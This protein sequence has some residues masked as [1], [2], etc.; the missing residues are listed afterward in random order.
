V[1]HALAVAALLA[2]ALAAGCG[3][4]SSSELAN[5][6]E[7]LVLLNQSDSIVGTAGLPL[8]T[9]IQL[10]AQDAN[11]NPIAGATIVW[12]ITAGNGSVSAMQDTTGSGGLV[13][14]IWTLGTLVGGNALNARAVSGITV[15]VAATGIAGPVASLFKALGDS[16]TVSVGTPSAPLAVQPLDRFGNV[17]GAG[18]IVNWTATGG[19]LS[20]AQ[21]TSDSTGI[22]RVTYTPSAAGTNTVT[23]T[24]QGT[25]P[26]TFTVFAR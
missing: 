5:V 8:A 4:T 15:D 21:T 3:D 7:N 24:A 14:V 20:A 22:V 25:A 2:G 17:T 19:A 18:V 12:Q 26:V 11:G 23:A 10:L 9:P 16:Q 1:H 6:P 13:S